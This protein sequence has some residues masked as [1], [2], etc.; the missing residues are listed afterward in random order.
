MRIVYPEL[1]LVIILIFAMACAGCSTQM[2]SIK[3]GDFGQDSSGGAGTG[4]PAGSPD[5]PQPV[6]QPGITVNASEVFGDHHDATYWVEYRTTNTFGGRVNTGTMKLENAHEDYQGTPAIHFRMTNTHE[7]GTTVTDTYYDIPMTAVL[8][9]TTTWINN[10]RIDRI[11]ETSQDLL[12][13]RRVKD[14]DQTVFTF[15]GFEPVTVPSGTYA[16]AGRYTA[17]TGDGTSTYWVVPGV[18]M[19]VKDLYRTPDGIEY[20]KEMVRWG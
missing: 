6:V 11:E 1:G 8:G 5:G 16:N 15:V 3:T 2:T 12:R 20:L 9:E 13:Q 18:P 19:P 7:G 4:V 14:K 17:P 10:G